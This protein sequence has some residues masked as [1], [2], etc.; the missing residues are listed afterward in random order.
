MYLEGSGI[1]ITPPSYANWKTS[2]EAIVA[3]TARSACAK[4]PMRWIWLV[5]CILR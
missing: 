5:M 1:A 2:T 4:R 3:V